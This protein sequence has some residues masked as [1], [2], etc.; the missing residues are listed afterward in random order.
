MQTRRIIP[1]LALS[2]GCGIAVHGAALAQEE[3]GTLEQRMACTPDVWR[4]CSDQ[5]PDVGRITACLRENTP[6]L[7]T[8]CRAVFESNASVQRPIAPRPQPYP[9]QRMRPAAP[10]PGQMQ[11]QRL[12]PQS[13]DED[14]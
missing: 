10:P 8:G 3:R 14:D 9:D 11:I 1:R 13:F 7:S 5:V 2:I 4:L 12:P 6:R